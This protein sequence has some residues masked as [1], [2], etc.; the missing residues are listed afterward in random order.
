M[1]IYDHS[2]VDNISGQAYLAKLLAMPVPPLYDV[3]D[4][5][6]RGITPAVLADRALAA[7][8]VHWQQ[9]PSNC[10]GEKTMAV[11]E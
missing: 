10:G 8:R 1:Q 11:A 6:H 5:H 2:I 4:I 3:F 9:P 7:V